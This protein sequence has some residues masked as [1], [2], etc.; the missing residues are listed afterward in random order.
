MSINVVTTQGTLGSRIIDLDATVIAIS[1]ERRPQLERVKDGS[2]GIG[3][4]RQRGQPGM[5]PP[6]EVIESWSGMLLPG[7]TPLVWR[8]AAY[9]FFDRIQLADTT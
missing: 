8:F 9:A 1:C 3:F 6:F 2:S 4:A 7:L 5:Q